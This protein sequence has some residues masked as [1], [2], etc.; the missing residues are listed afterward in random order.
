MT[1]LCGP[2]SALLLHGD[3]GYRDV[4]LCTLKRLGSRCLLIAEIM[5]VN[6][7]LGPSSAVHSLK[8]EIND[9]NSKFMGLQFC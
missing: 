3:L 2:D 8:A 4:C 1:A 7:A 6:V 5:T 9:Y